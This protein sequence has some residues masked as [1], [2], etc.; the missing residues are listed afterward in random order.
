MEERR[1]THARTRIYTHTHI[2]AHILCSECECDR[3]FSSHGKRPKGESRSKVGGS[4]SVRQDSLFAG[5][6][7]D[8]STVRPNSS[9]KVRSR[10]RLSVSMLAWKPH[11]HSCAANHY[12][13]P[14]SMGAQQ[15]FAQDSARAELA[16]FAKEQLL[17]DLE[18]NAT[19]TFSVNLHSPVKKVVIILGKKN[20]HV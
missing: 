20:G 11:A 10:A 14:P 7:C 8:A 5:H 3:D 17:K 15:D 18:L 9:S 16:R 1:Y 4:H 13:L 6:K 19:S 12:E 2:H